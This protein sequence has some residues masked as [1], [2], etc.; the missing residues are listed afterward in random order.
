M[1]RRVLVLGAG[2]VGLS[3]A[4]LRRPQGARGHGPGRRRRGGRRLLVRQRGP[5]RAQPRR[6]P[7]GAGRGEAGPAMDARPGGPVRR[8]APPRPRPARL[9]LPLLAGGDARTRP[10]VGAAA[11]RPAPGQPRDAS[12]SGRRPGATTSASGPAGCW[13]CAG[14]RTASPKRPAPRRSRGRWACPR[15]P[16]ARRRWRRWSRSCAWTWPGAVRYPLDCHLSPDCLMASLRRQAGQAG[17]AVRLAHGGHGVARV[18]RA[19]GGRPRPAAGERTAD[20]YVLAAGTW[21][22]D[23]ARGL[24]LRAAHA[25]GQG[26]QPHAAGAQT[27]ARATRRSSARRAWR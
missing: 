2:V 8:P 23:L 26:L 20:E 14:R 13:S 6:P 1:S 3:A 11:A 4:L 9:G 10:A 12:P 15:T 7:G 18:A 5:D 25:G 21:S 27:P 16:S 22:S 24:G 17:V 19:R